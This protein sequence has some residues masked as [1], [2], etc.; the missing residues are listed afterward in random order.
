VNAIWSIIILMIVNT[1]MNQV[2]SRICFCFSDFPTVDLPLF[3][4]VSQNTICQNKWTQKGKHLIQSA[5][6]HNGNILRL[7]VFHYDGVIDVL[8]LPIFPEFITSLAVDLSYVYIKDMQHLWCLI[9]LQ[10]FCG[11]SF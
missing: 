6:T 7:C 2:V 8:L 10:L 1:N 9:L 4:C 11:I 3:L 5:H